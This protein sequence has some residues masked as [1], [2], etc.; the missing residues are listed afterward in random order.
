MLSATIIMAAGMGTRMKSAVPKVLHR[1]LGRPL[2]QFPVRLALDGTDAPV[3]VV[4]GEF[5]DDLRR[6]SHVDTP[7]ERVRFARQE[8]ADGTAGAVRAG[9]TAIPRADDGARR[10][11]LILNGDVPCLSPETMARLVAAF[12]GGLDVSFLGFHAEDPAG[13]GRVL[14][15][16]SGAILGIR[17]EKELDPEDREIDLVN[18]GIYLVEEGLLREFIAG[19]Q[20]SERHGEYLLTDVVEYALRLGRTAD[21]VV[22]KDEAELQG[23][24]T[25]VH[26]ALVNQRLRR[27]R[28]EALMLDGVTLQNPD[29]VDVDY[30]VTVGPDTSLEQ[31]VCLR[32]E[33][34]IAG[35]TVVARGTVVADCTIGAHCHIL[36][37]CMLESSEIH[38]GCT[39]GPFAH[40]RP[41]TVLED[42]A[43]L[44]NYCETKKT[45]VG[46]GSKV[47]HLTYLGDCEVG[48]K[49]NVGAGTITCNYDGVNKH[50]T[51]LGDRVF[52][53]SDVQLVAPVT[54]GDGAVLAAGATITAD[55][56]P[57]ALAISRTEQVNVDGYAERKR[58]ERE[59]D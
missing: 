44:G 53:G 30:S 7:T 4:G 17:E 47:N 6:A 26:L 38:E 14:Y 58:K 27:A 31:G 20:K 29:T 10:G 13:Y 22:V 34:H 16:D 57:G 25:R 23:V 5:L 2:V 46:R 40:T 36:P 54:V 49:V 9:L 24:N 45:R 42:G 15:D 41:G 35:Q 51:V 33:T 18:G 43:K 59:G 21:V 55:V 28:N 48:K 50:K 8:T 1:I 12:E 52:V 56:P 3:V 11:I 39:I 37:Y 19:V 32:G